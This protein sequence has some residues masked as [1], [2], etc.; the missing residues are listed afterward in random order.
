MAIRAFSNTP[1]TPTISAMSTLTA[2]RTITML[3][4]SEASPPIQRGAFIRP[5]AVAPNTEGE[6]V[7]PGNGRISALIR[8][9]VRFLHGR[10]PRV[11]LS[12]PSALRGIIR[13]T[14]E[15]RL[16]IYP[17]EYAVQGVLTKRACI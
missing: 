1:A 7:L 15:V 6:N 5:S 10:G 11:A 16:Y 2:T 9:G 12:F 4:M 14:P 17:S 13:K 8:P 3:T